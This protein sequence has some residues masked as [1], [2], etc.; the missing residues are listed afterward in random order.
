VI[1]AD[2]STLAFTIRVINCGQTIFYQLAGADL[3][4]VEGGGEVINYICHG[5]IMP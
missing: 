2:K 4:G 3:F 5:K 1:S